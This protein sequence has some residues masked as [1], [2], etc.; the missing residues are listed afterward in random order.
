MVRIIRTNYIAFIKRYDFF[1]SNEWIFQEYGNY[2]YIL[3]YYIL[4]QSADISR[5][6]GLDLVEY[7]LYRIV[8]VLYALLSLTSLPLLLYVEVKHIFGST[9]HRNI[10]IYE[11][12]S[13]LISKPCD[14]FP[15]FYIY[16]FFH[17]T[18]I[19][20]FYGM[21]LSLAAM[22]CERTVATV[23]SNKYESN[24]IALSLLLLV[25]TI[26]A[27]VADMSYVYEIR[28]FNA[29]MWSMIY[30]PPA[31]VD[32]FNQVALL[33]IFISFVCIATFQMLSRYNEKKYSV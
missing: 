26:V 17:L 21:I 3:K 2:F 13:S 19:L 14:F 5:E 30:V 32:K 12:I 10:K 7:P 16:A 22:C 20:P 15:S 24:G 6:E 23:R 33:N 27:T 29:K 9:F 25:V 18:S 4:L 11:I 8:Q 28:D 31:A 1:L